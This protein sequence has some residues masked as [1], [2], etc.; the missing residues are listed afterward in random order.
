[1]LFII[2]KT[3]KTL[4]YS[5]QKC[6]NKIKILRLITL[7]YNYKSE[8]YIKDDLSLGIFMD[9]VGKTASTHT[10]D[11]IEIIY[12][13]DG[14]ATEQINDSEYIL[15]RGD[16]LFINYGSTHARKNSDGYSYINICFSPETL[17]NKII[18]KENAFY[19]LSLSAFEEIQSE[20]FE[21]KIHFSGEERRIIEAILSDMLYEQSKN[22]SERAAVLESYMTVLITKI[23]R[24]MRPSKK[25]DTIEIDIWGALSEY[26][27]KNFKKKLTLSDLAK[28]CFYNPSYFSRAFKEK[29]NVSLTEYIGS[30]RARAASEML[31]KTNK[32][33]DEIAEE[34]GYG[35]KSGLYRAFD[36]FYGCTP[37]EYRH[38][39]RKNDTDN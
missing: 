11:F 19:I 29:F 10:H 23:I 27:D 17:A 2:R 28:R 8:K 24:K 9:K 3:I 25:T 20:S 39:M 4:D 15:K 7:M 30:E 34:C 6:Y 38:T 14:V 12:V 26:I 22:L 1:M 33:I 5:I 37:T 32:S 21:G 36:K 16:M 35:E 31:L 18:N 13:L